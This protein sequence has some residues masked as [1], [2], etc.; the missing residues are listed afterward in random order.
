MNTILRLRHWHVFVIIV[1]ALFVSN[2][3]HGGHSF[4][5]DL[6]AIVGGTLFFLWPFITGIALYR[7]LP[8]GV[9]LSFRLFIFNSLVWLLAHV[10]II[11]RSR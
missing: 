11:V 2:L 3:S 8:P 1:L 4:A 7:M 6:Y 10:F 9:S 5:Y